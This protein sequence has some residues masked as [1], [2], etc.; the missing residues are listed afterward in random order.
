MKTRTKAIL[1]GITAVLV[2]GIIAAG[3]T[4]GS[5]PA[6]ANVIS[7]IGNVLTNPS[8]TPDDPASPAAAATVTPTAQD[9]AL[10]VTITSEQCFGSAGCDLQWTVR[11]AMNSNPGV[12]YP[13]EFTLTY[14]VPGVQDGYTGSI[15]FTN[16]GAQYST[17]GTEGFGQTTSHVD[18][19]TATAVSVV[20]Q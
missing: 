20:A 6:P 18:T 2:G 19:L 5:T 4:G 13:G 14:T 11:A 15:D 8:L 7:K 12:T 3:T 16:A 10:T 17:L 1:G 9:F